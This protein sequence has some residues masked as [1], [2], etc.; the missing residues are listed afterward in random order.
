MLFFIM[1]GLDFA[2]RSLHCSSVIRPGP[3]SENVAT[4]F[5]VFVA[6]AARHP[7]SRRRPAAWNGV[8][9]LPAT[10]TNSS[11]IVSEQGQAVIGPWGLVPSSEGRMDF[12]QDFPGQAASRPIMDDGEGSVAVDVACQPGRDQAQVAVLGLFPVIG[13]SR[14]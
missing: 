12:R 4:G 6:R 3:G 9:T 7:D 11:P 10:Q 1:L 2:N 14:Q 5:L 8:S 13:M